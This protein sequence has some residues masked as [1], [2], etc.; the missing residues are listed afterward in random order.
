MVTADRDFVYLHQLLI[1]YIETERSP[2]R[3]QPAIFYTHVQSILEP[4][5]S[6]PNKE[7]KVMREVRS[8][9]KKGKGTAKEAFKFHTYFYNKFRKEILAK[10]EE[11]TGNKYSKK[12]KYNNQRQ[13]HN[14]MR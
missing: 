3:A 10:R 1:K 5:N 7:S 13:R 11:L 6:V 9:Y 8:R 2:K 14:G 12:Q 4:I